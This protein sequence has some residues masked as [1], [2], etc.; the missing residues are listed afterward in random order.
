MYNLNETDYIPKYIKISENIKQDISSGLLKH[1]Q[2]IYSEKDIMAKYDV[3]STTARKS[4]EVL[5][6]E[7]LIESIQGKGSFILQTKILRSLKKVISFTENVKRQSL[8]PSSKVIEKSV[9]GGYTEY[10]KKLNLLEDEKILKIIRVRYGD[11]IPLLIDTRY[12]NMKY[13]PGIEERDLS[14]SLYEIYNSYNIKIA[15]SK[16]ILQMSFLDEKNAKLLNCKK[17]DPV[18]RIEGTL[19]LEDFSSV[20]YEEDLWNGAVFSFYVEASL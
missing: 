16:Q 3:S 1:G 12:I 9:L 17:F 11:D 8:V 6:R 15:H 4:L 5:R 7:N 2:K 10:H 19:Y 20:E 13:C 14:T 18:I